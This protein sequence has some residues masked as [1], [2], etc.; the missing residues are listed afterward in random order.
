MTLAVDARWLGPHGI[1]RFAK[2]VIA[3]LPNP[4]TVRLSLPPLHPLD[5]LELS[6]RL[7][8]ER[9]TLFFSP[10]FNPPI[11]SPC[12]FVFTIHDLI[13]LHVSGESS[14]FKRAYY[15]FVVRPAAHRAR[16]VLTDSEYSRQQILEWSGLSPDRVRVVWCGVDATFSPAGDVYDP[17]FPY[18]FTVVNDKSHKNLSGLLEAFAKSGL[19]RELKLLVNC[20]ADVWAARVA[21][22]GLT[23]S[24]VFQ[25]MIPDVILPS[26][27]RGATAFVF[28]SLYEGFGLPPL[29]A[30]ACGVPVLSSNRTSIPEVIGDAGVLIDPEDLEVFA[31]ELRRIVSDSDLRQRLRQSGPARAQLYTWDRTGALVREALGV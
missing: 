3:R 28:P 12:P 30:M 24:V 19:A 29:E 15:W 31:D 25:G 14:R 26:F 18:L 1:G 27:Y 17:G 16:F 21:E 20:K 23:D 7:W 2:E 13:H 9:P 10:G 11:S 5:P 6:T 4:N 22:L 8:L